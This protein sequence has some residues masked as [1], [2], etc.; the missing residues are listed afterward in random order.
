MI[1]QKEEGMDTDIIGNA[2]QENKKRKNLVRLLK[3]QFWQNRFLYLGIMLLEFGCV[4]FGIIANLRERTKLGHGIH[5]GD[6]GNMPMVGTVMVILFLCFRSY[7]TVRNE[8]ISMYPGTRETRYFSRVLLDHLTFLFYIV[9]LAVLYLAVFLGYEVIHLF[10]PEISMIYFFS[11]KYLFAGCVRILLFSMMLYSVVQLGYTLMYW[12]GM[13]RYVVTCLIILFIGVIWIYSYCPNY[14]AV[15]QMLF[16]DVLNWRQILSRYLPIWAVALALNSSIVLWKKK[17]LRPVRKAPGWLLA[18]V[19]IFGAGFDTAVE[20]QELTRDGDAFYYS[21]NEQPDWSNREKPSG[22]F[23]VSWVEKDRMSFLA[24]IETGCIIYS[25]KDNASKEA[26]ELSWENGFSPQ[27]RICSVSQMKEKDSSFDV[28]KVSEDDFLLYLEAPA[29][30]YNG[31][32][33]YQDVMNRIELKRIRGNLFYNCDD[34]YYVFNHM[35]GNAYYLAGVAEEEMDS[36]QTDSMLYEMQLT[37]VVDDETM[38]NWRIYK[39]KM[40]QD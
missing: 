14:D 39:R 7:D 38:K 16:S 11:W 21:Y 8:K 31:K 4:V 33:L 3:I 37:V 17:P 26:Q 15:V 27:F 40:I 2:V 28:S 20:L 35:F 9:Y 1:E 25:E 23:V 34:C 29:V 19:L 32:S 22:E 24:K 36:W 12:L 10:V 13:V 18:T 30:N 6:M 5:A